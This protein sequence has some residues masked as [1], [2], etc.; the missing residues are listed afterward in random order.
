ME[1]SPSWHANR[2]S[3]SQEIAHISWNPEVPYRIY[4]KLQS[5]PILNKNLTKGQS[6]SEAL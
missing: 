3:N 1:Q 2:S 4:N 6:E 5:F